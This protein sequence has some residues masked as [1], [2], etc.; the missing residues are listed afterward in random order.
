MLT[1][2]PPKFTV[3]LA[4]SGLM[5]GCAQSGPFTTYRTS[6]GTLKASVSHLESANDQLRQE[7]DNLKAENRE[8]ENRLVQ[9]ESV[10]GD[11]SA[12]LDDAKDLLRRRGFDPGESRAST[13]P[14]DRDEPSNPGPTRPAGQSVRK[15]R[16]PP[17]VQIPG[18]LDPTPPAADGEDDQATPPRDP[19]GSQS[20]FEDPNRW[21]PVARG[22]SEPSSKTR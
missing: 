10:N 4:A 20:R 18:Q 9:E 21:L 22:I 8:I 17:F 11:L 5:A 6:M 19:F 14:R 1:G 12:R 7:V 15:R 13:A 16:K 3:F 2:H